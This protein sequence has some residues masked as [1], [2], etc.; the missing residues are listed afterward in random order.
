[1]RTA[2]I[3]VRLVV[4]MCPVFMAVVLGTDSPTCTANNYKHTSY[5]G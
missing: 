5:S 3:L 4:L 1:M 2:C